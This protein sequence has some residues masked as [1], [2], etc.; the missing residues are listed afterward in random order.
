MSL[1]ALIFN[2]FGQFCL[3]FFLG[4]LAI[5]SGAAIANRNDLSPFHTRLATFVLLVPPV[6]SLIT[7]ALLIYFYVSDSP[8]ASHLWHLLPVGLAALCMLYLHKVLD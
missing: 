1:S 8:L 5:F 6:A 4:M 3:A 7:C 2:V